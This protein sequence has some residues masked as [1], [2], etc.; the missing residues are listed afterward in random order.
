VEIAVKY[1]DGTVARVGDRVRIRN[2]DTGVVI[3]SMDTSEYSSDAPKSDW[4]HVGP[5]IIV[6]TDAGALVQ[7][8]DPLPPGLLWRDQYPDPNAR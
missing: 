3:A 4:E 2:G 8:E 5:G 6:R 7:F 1:D